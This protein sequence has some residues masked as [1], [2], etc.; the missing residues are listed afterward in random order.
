MNSENILFLRDNLKF[1]G[2]GEGTQLNDQLEEYIFHQTQEFQLQMESFYD[3]DYKVEATLHFRK[4]DNTDLYFFNKYE[5]ILRKGD[6]P[7]KDR[8]QTFY[9][10]KGSGVTLKE[11][12]NLLQGR[13]VNKNLI[14][15]DGERYNAWIQ[16]NFE[17]MTPNHNYRM[18]QF[19]LQ[20]GYELE[21][22]L[23]K[24]PIRELKIDESRTALLKA[25]KRGNLQPV[26]FLKAKKAEKMFIEANPQFKTINIYTST[27][28]AL[29]KLY[30][31][32]DSVVKVDIPEKPG[33]PDNEE[34][35]DDHS[36]TFEEES[37]DH[38][39]AVEEGRGD[40][41]AAVEEGSEEVEEATVGNPAPP[42]KRRP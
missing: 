2:F 20:Y 39:V 5:A 33:D 28:S 3:D 19:R 29:Q 21:K 10:S 12:Y 6:A 32:K 11:A 41:S 9:I 1:L 35:K 27:A 34:W 18:K 4:G 38:S 36:V 37:E 7:E 8:M 15:F 25:L 17:E 26:H 24:Y 30:K 14:S 13:S 42:K 22:V 40:H 16:L 23:E 31:K